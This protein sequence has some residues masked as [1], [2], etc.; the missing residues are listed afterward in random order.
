MRLSTNTVTESVK[1]GIYRIGLT[2][3]FISPEIPKWS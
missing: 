1:G 3:A 2:E